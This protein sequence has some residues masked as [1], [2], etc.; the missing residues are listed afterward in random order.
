MYETGLQD[1]GEITVTNASGSAS[2]SSQVDF[3]ASFTNG[4]LG[5][6]GVGSELTYAQKKGIK[7]NA[8]KPVVIS[9]TVDKTEEI[10]IVV[11]DLITYLNSKKGAWLR[12]RL[13]D[14]NFETHCTIHGLANPRDENDL[15][16]C[17]S[18][19]ASETESP[20]RE[21]CGVILHSTSDNNKWEYILV[22]FVP[23]PDDITP[24]N[25]NTVDV[26]NYPLNL[27]GNYPLE[28]MTNQTLIN[29]G[30]VYFDS[31]GNIVNKNNLPIRSDYE[32]VSLWHT[33]PCGTW[34]ASDEDAKLETSHPQ[35]IL[36]IEGGFGNQLGVKSF[37]F[38]FNSKDH[39]A[40]Y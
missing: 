29:F 36:N 34:N 20:V 15:T 35:I 2:F 5:N 30:K 16:P 11:D 24:K 25:T 1:Y 32:V 21:R 4:T 31:Q 14:I 13:E 33:H 18:Q 39:Q 3:H 38:Y 23:S 8:Q 6:E 7:A 40:E 37:N 19:I 28:M 26:C 27:Q 12:K 10:P 22:E 17:E 9:I